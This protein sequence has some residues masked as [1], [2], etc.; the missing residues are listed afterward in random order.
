MGTIKKDS[1][2]LFWL[3]STPV[4][5][6]PLGPPRPQG[7]VAIYNAAAKEV[8]DELEIPIIDLY[9]FV[10]KQCG[11]DEHYTSCPGF[12]KS[13][14]VHFEKAG[15]EKM[16]EFIKSSIEEKLVWV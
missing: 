11:G 13:K 7:D 1:G 16:A 6:G 4:P 8:M 15:Y 2:R 14:N 12:Q 9:A 10:I 5:N 3:S